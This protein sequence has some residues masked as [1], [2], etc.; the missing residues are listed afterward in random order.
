M[1][2]LISP[3]DGVLSISRADPTQRAARCGRNCWCVCRN[4]RRSGHG[5][6]GRPVGSDTQRSSLSWRPS[7]S[8]STLQVSSHLPP[9]AVRVAAPATVTSVASPLGRLRSGRRT[10]SVADPRPTTTIRTPSARG[11]GCG[12][13][14]R[15]RSEHHSAEPGEAALIRRSVARTTSEPADPN[16]CRSPA[17]R[18]PTPPVVSVL[19]RS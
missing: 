16:P 13:R 15:R 1:I 8:S 5:R 7:V 10:Q 4:R 18:G 9:P 12:R 3:P 6:D 17:L 2:E 11:G 19:W 14:P